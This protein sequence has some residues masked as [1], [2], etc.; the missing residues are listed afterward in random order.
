MQNGIIISPLPDTRARFKQLCE[1]ARIC[2]NILCCIDL[3]EAL[4][5]LTPGNNC[6]IIFISSNYAASDIA[7]FIET[8]KLTEVGHQTLF[9]ILLQ[10]NDQDTITVANNLFAGVYAF[11]CEP[12][13]IDTVQESIKVAQH[14]QI[15]GTH[16]RLRAATGLILSDM[17]EGPDESKENIWTRVERNCKKFEEITGESIAVTIVN[18]IRDTKP[19]KRMPHYEGVSKRVKQLSMKYFTDLFGGVLRKYR[20]EKIPKRETISST[21]AEKLGI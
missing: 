19:S 2:N 6:D 8:A 17:L 7:D 20:N 5:T 9:V 14:V 18:K 12:Y 10:S 15:S 16:S 11:L 21:E 1:N 13:S 3:D 4:Q